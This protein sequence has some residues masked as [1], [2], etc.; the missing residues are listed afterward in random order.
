M[1]EIIDFTKYKEEL[2]T[3][4][5]KLEILLKKLG[6]DQ[7]LIDFAVKRQKELYEENKSLGQFNFSVSLPGLLNNEE[8]LRLH[9]HIQSEMSQLIKKSVDYNMKLSGRLL[10]AEIKLFQYESE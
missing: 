4:P 6:A 3:E 2:T 5:G 7:Q 10:L 9:S 8:Q 1:A